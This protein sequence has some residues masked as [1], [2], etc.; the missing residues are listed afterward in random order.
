L[1]E[2]TN[3]VIGL[4]AALVALAMKW[5]GEVDVPP[6]GEVTLTQMPLPHPPAGTTWRVNV[7]EP[8]APVLS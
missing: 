7:C 8:K 3:P 4:P 5:T 2:T 6:V 1:A